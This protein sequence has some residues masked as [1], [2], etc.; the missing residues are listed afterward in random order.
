M[1]DDVRQFRHLMALGSHG[2][3]SRAAESLGIT[4]S[5]LSQSIQR[6]EDIYGI[7]LFERSRTGIIATIY[8]ERLVSVARRGMALLEQA[9]R[10]L[11][12]IKNLEVGRVIIG[13]DPVITELLLAPA[14][15]WVLT[16]YPKLQFVMKS[17]FWE[18]FRDAVEIG[19]VDMY[20]GMLPSES[21]TMFEVHEIA[22]PAIVVYCREGHPLVSRSDIVLPDIMDYPRIGPSMPDWFFERMLQS[23]GGLSGPLRDD[24]FVV[25][26]DGGMMRAV[27]RDT[28][29]VCGGFR[30]VIQANNKGGEFAILPIYSDPF[31]VALPGVIVLRKDHEVPPAGLAIVKMVKEQ[32]VLL[33]AIDAALAAAA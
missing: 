16:R 18:D 5:A 23:T 17:G 12:L 1:L 13:C 4:K 30:P 19:E 9:D 25:T 8:G 6:M 24:M 11:E 27:V 14:L 26:N 3:I 29:A 20:V 33:S 32:A 22:L 2:T 10:E 28:D 31:G 21:V 7:K 15:A